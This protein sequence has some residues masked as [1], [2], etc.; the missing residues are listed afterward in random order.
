MLKQLLSVFL[1]SHCPFCQRSTPELFCKYCR[2]KLISHQLTV[3]ADQTWRGDLP[4]FAWGKYDGQ[5]KRAIAL[6]KYNQQPDIGKILGELL[7]Q[8]W[9]THGLIDPSQKISV[10]PI[11]LSSQKRK[12]RG[13]NQAEIIARSFCDLTGYELTYK[14]LLRIKDTQAMFNLSPEARSIN[15]QG[16]FELGKKLPKYPV[17]LL[18]DIYTL[19]NTVNEATKILRQHQIK[20]IGTVVVAKTIYR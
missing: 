3:N 13:F 11:P 1:E 19:G 15:I 4:L 2:K 5:L 14:A 17:L 8:A 12:S 7:A 9:L 20:V 6:M 16:A 18:D 10:I